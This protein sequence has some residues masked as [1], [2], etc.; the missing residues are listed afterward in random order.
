MYDIIGGLKILTVGFLV[1][2]NCPLLEGLRAGLDQSVVPYI[3]SAQT[4]P[5]QT[6]ASQLD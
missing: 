1:R 4:R 2:R 3:H 5:D 6:K